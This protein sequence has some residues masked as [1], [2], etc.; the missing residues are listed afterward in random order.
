MIREIMRNNNVD[1][2]SQFYLKTILFAQQLNFSQI[3]QRIIARRAEGPIIPYRRRRWILIHF[4]QSSYSSSSFSRPLPPRSSSRYVE[5]D[6]RSPRF[7]VGC[8]IRR[9]EYKPSGPDARRARGMSCGVMARGKQ[10]DIQ[11]AVL[12]YGNARDVKMTVGYDASPV[13]GILPVVTA[14]S[15]PR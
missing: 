2:I 5:V 1:C 10:E 12:L 11:M 9:S 13:A 7:D 14:T 15:Q 6:I 8:V 3:F 4:R